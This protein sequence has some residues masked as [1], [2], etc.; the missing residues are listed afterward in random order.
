MVFLCVILNTMWSGMSLSVDM[1][2]TLWCIVLVCHHYDV[3]TNYI[4]SVY[5]GLS[6]KGLWVFLVVGES[7][8]VLL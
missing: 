7:Q 5:G 3:F 4:G 6:E 8:S 2:L 1:H